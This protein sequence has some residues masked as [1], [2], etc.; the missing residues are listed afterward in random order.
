MSTTELLENLYASVQ[1][2]KL[3]DLSQPQTGD[4]P[5]P[6]KPPP[7][8]SRSQQALR[9]LRREALQLNAAV[10]S[11]RKSADGAR[12]QVEA[13]RADRER[14]WLKSCLIEHI[15]SVLCAIE[16]RRRESGQAAT[17]SKSNISHFE[18]T[19]VS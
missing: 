9:A 6:S 11:E 13:I 5:A 10:G 12:K 4:G 17:K 18:E 1:E 14:N 19:E 16:S 2:V 8:T 15:R 3:P 7:S